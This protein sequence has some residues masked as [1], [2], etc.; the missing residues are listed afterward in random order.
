MYDERVSI[1]LYQMM[2]S[3][4]HYTM[5]TSAFLS[6][7]LHVMNASTLAFV[8]VVMKLRG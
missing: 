4:Y 1:S 8:L 2:Y 3:N 6:S 7:I 5:V